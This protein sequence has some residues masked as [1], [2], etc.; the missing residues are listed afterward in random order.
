M[1]N[2]ILIRQVP[3]FSALD[4]EQFGQIV[5][6][7][8]MLTLAE[9]ETLFELG[10]SCERFY[11]MVAGQIKLFRVSEDGNEKIIEIVRPGKL[12]AEAVMFMPLSRYPVSA[13]ALTASTVYGFDNR[14]FLTMLRESSALGMRLLA[15]LSVRLHEQ[16]NEIDN[17]SLQNATF[18]VIGYLVDLLP[19]PRAEAAVI[20]L[21]VPKQVIASRLSIT[22][23]TFSR[24]LHTMA[25]EEIVAI[26]GKTIAVQS[27][28]RLREFGRYERALYGHAR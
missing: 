16:L 25:K 20:E 28:R 5:H 9:G 18:R 15:K 1:L 3:L 27:V 22:P 4:D 17:L 11:L 12:F 7:T 23:E 10:Q 2:E 24:I 8:H 13:A 6:S 26:Q 21:T 19:D 14:V